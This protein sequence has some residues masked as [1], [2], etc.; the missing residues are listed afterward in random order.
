MKVEDYITLNSLLTQHKIDCFKVYANT[1][2]MSKEREKAFLQVRY[3]NMYHA[4]G[5][6]KSLSGVFCKFYS[7]T[8]PLS[9]LKTA[10]IVLF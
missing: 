1:D 8:Y 9:A 5:S 7:L 2:L 10:V 4:P 3:I 6:E